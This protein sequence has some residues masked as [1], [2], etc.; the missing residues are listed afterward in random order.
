M[1]RSYWLGMDY[2]QSCEMVEQ[3][4]LIIVVVTRTRVVNWR[5]V[6]SLASRRAGVIDLKADSDLCIILIIVVVT[7]TRVVNWFVDSLASRW[8][9]VIDLKADSDLWNYFINMVSQVSF[10][11]SVIVELVS[12]IDL[13][14][15]QT[16][17]VI[18]IVRV[19]RIIIVAF[20]FISF[21]IKL[22]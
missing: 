10:N 2:L 3:S 4:L 7:H 14:E 15:H 12:P 6:N 9:G 21:K 16:I 20:T 19:I 22:L 5:V 18:L 17:E 13:K 11:N 1:G 8:A